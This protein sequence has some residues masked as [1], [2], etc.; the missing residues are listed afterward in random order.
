LFSLPGGLTVQLGEAAFESSQNVVHKALKCLWGIAQAEGHEGELENAE[1]SDNGHILYTIRMEGG[2]GVRSHQNDLG[3]DGTLEKLVGV[4]VDISDEI[5]V[6]DCPGV[7]WSAIAAR[8]P[9]V[10][11]LGHDM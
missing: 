10:V 8:A 11:F 4:I 9:T 6:W 7:E 1:R 5:V 3:E 2:L